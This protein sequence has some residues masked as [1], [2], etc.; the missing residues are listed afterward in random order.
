MDT[1]MLTI[2]FAALLTMEVFVLGVAGAIFIAGVYQIV[3]DS[4]R[5]RTAISTGRAGLPFRAG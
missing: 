4:A 1:I 5:R 2:K 3:R